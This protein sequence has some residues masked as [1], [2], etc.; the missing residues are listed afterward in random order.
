[1]SVRSRFFACLATVACLSSSQAAAPDASRIRKEQESLRNE[2]RNAELEYNRLVRQKDLPLPATESLVPIYDSFQKT[3]AG[4]E[5]LPSVPMSIAGPSLVWSVPGRTVPRPAPAAE[6]FLCGFGD[7]VV[8]FSGEFVRTAEDVSLPDRGGIGF[9]FVRTYASF[10]TADCGLGPGWDCNWNVTL[11]SEDDTALLLHCNG[12]DIRFSFQNG[13]WSPEPG[14]FLRLDVD[15]DKAVVVHPDL[16]RFEFEPATEPGAEERRWRLSAIASRHGE[17]S[18]NRLEVRYLDG[19]DRIHFVTDPF[20]QRIDFSYDATGHL[21]QVTAPHDAVRFVYA[22]N[23]GTLIQAIRP[24][25]MKT[26]ATTVEPK[27][28]YVYDGEHRLIRETPTGSPSL[29]VAYD[30]TG[31]VVTCAFETEK[32]SQSWS[33][34]YAPGETTVRGPAPTPETRYRFGNAPHPSL[35]D[36][37]L[38]PARGAETKYVYNADFLVSE[39]TDAIGAKTA[40]VYDSENPNPVHRGNRLAM[41]RTPAAGIPADW[42][43]IGT[44]TE[45]HAD[46][47]AVVKEVTYQ[48]DRDGVRT[49]VK[50]ETFEYSGKD[51]MPVRHDDGGIVSRTLFNR[52]GNPV[53]EIDADDRCTL[54]YYAESLPGAADYALSRGIPDGGGL[55]IELV[56]DADAKQIQFVCTA[57]GAKPPR[58]GDDKTMPPAN[59]RTRF[60]LDVRGNVIRE[61]C[62]YSDTLYFLNSQGSVIAESDAQAGTT[63]HEYLPS[64]LTD[65]LYREF[66]PSPDATFQGES[67]FPFGERRFVKETFEYDSL[68]QLSAHSPT[69]EASRDGVPRFRYERYPN[70]RVRRFRNPSGLCREDVVDSTTGYLVEQRMVGDGETAVLATDLRYHPDGTVRSSVDVYGGKTEFRLDGFGNVRSTI[71]PNGRVDTRRVDALGRVSEEVSED[72]KGNILSRTT[73][74]YD[75]PYGLLSKTESWTGTATETVEEI[76]YDGNGRKTAERESHEDSWSYTLYD[77]L[78]RV[79]A[80][81]DP[82]GDCSVT[83]YRHDREVYTRNV[84]QGTS[85]QKTVKTNGVLSELNDCGRVVRCVPVDAR[86]NIVEEREEFFAYDAIGQTIRSANALAV[87]ETDYDSQGRSVRVRTTPKRTDQGERPVLT[88]TEYLADGRV[89]RKETG[90]TALV[91]IGKKNDVN[92]SFVEAPQET[93]TEYDG[94]GRPIRTIQPDGLTVTTVYNGHSLPERMIWTHPAEAGELRDLSFAYSD[95]GQVLSIFDASKGKTL[96]ECEYDALGRCVR[97]LDHGSSGTVAILSVYDSLG[98]IAEEGLS[99]NGRPFPVQ[100]FRY[101]AGKGVTERFWRGLDRPNKIHYWES[102]AEKVDGAGRITSLSL[103]GERFATWEYLG[104]DVEARAIRESGLQTKWTY[105][106][107]CEPVSQRFFRGSVVFGTLE[108]AYGPQGQAEYSSTRLRGRSGKEYSYSTYSDFDAYRRLTAQNGETSL[109]G[110]A[111]WNKRRAQILGTQKDSLQAVEAV[112]MAYDQTDSLWLRYT[113]EL[114]DSFRADAFRPVQNP[115]YVSAGKVQLQLRQ[116]PP[117]ELASNRETT[118]AVWQ[119]DDGIDHLTAEEDVFDSLGNLVEFDGTYWNGDRKYPA[120]WTLTYDALGRL[121][122]MTAK[123]RENVLL[124]TNGQQIATLRF[125]Y[126]SRNRRIGMTVEDRTGR[127]RAPTPEK[128]TYTVYSGDEQKLVLEDVGAE[129]GFKLREEYLWGSGSREFLMAAMPENAAEKEKASDFSCRYYFQQDRSLNVILVTKKGANG[130][131]TVSTASYLGFGEN[132]TRA[133]VERIVSS[134]S[135]DFAASID[136]SLDGASARW[137][138]AGNKPHYLQLDLEE[139]SPLSQLNVWTAD[140]FPGTFAVFV[141]PSGEKT[142]DTAGN[143]LEWMDRHQKE[144]CVA[145]SQKG[146]YQERT[147][148]SGWD[149]PYRINLGGQKGKHVAIVWDGAD[150]PAGGVEVREF[151]VVRMPDNPSAIAFAGQWLDRETDLYY[152]INRYRKAGSEKFISPDPLGFLDGP[153]M[154]AYAHANPLEWHDP[155]G[156]L[157]FL[158]TAGI[159]AAVGAIIGGGGYAL[160]CWLTGDEFSWKEFAIQTVIGATVGFVSGLTFGACTPTGASLAGIG[161]WNMVGAGAASGATGGFVQGTMDSALHDG[162]FSESLVFG[163]RGATIGGVTGAISGAV[164][165]GLARLSKPNYVYRVCRPDENPANGL[166]PKNPTDTRDINSFVLHGSKSKYRFIATTKDLSIAQEHLKTA[167]SGSTIVKIDLNKINNK[168]Y[169]LTNS[170]AVK[171]K[172]I[173]GV[174]AINRANASQEVD[175][176]GPII[177]KAISQIPL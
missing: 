56:E 174:T 31:R 95:M 14:E 109:P 82:S 140:R 50:T 76:L 34:Q 124:V 26:L 16:S 91:L 120:K 110:A 72:G 83:L 102:E 133:K 144:Y 71:L 33:M 139:E 42:R 80:V 115:V 148:G 141:L 38:V 84:V 43:E 172:I 105:N 146:I 29:A 47:A 58:F 123:A 166:V 154:Y 163:V 142:P 48:T 127:N 121:V 98:R 128:K 11:R 161:F 59:R 15:G 13:S 20:G 49:N 1:M 147:K 122:V 41:R 132:A 153:N 156:R 12:R 63:V 79:V 134:A 103:D 171:K 70:G 126:D 51:L 32:Q 158:A 96:R 73:F 37:V 131:E 145:V 3:A 89:V 101:D 54:H 66:V 40:F 165:G 116:P 62:G 21:V 74:F 30:E 107:L 143:L 157:A 77:G 57:I 78:G 68:L 6:S 155:D 170:S 67:V 18:V 173:R 86:G 8:P 136:Q 2:Y 114:S 69:E 64:G 106:D 36:C 162:S 104:T 169:D 94:L 55:P 25:R 99:L 113:G 97:S 9:S 119:R 45:Y 44:E 23:D 53:V 150:S 129:K 160:R 27:T 159:G 151:E 125:V 167:P 52:Y 46:I 92:P 88:T 10:S 24:R 61:Q 60:A 118:T 149:S 35:P 108:Y 152:Q 135:G 164:A 93:K 28:D 137:F 175:I 100:V 19:C 17:G 22:P 112:R 117:L 176:E 7:S 130:P 81:R 111:G 168:I 90:N 39:E 138:P 85:L 4:L 75:N 87:T 177:A 65:C 5:S